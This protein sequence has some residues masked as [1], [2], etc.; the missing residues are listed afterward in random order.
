MTDKEKLNMLI[1]AIDY[2]F[3]N[4]TEKDYN[5]E[6]TYPVIDKVKFVKRMLQQEQPSEDLLDEADRTYF[7][8]A[9]LN[10]K[11][12]GYEIKKMT[13][14]EFRRVAHHFANWQKE[15]IMEDAV[16][17]TVDYPFIGHDFPNIYPNYRELKDYCDKNG[18]KDNA[19]VKLIMI[20]E[21]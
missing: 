17:A 20:K 21:D 15:K 4:P 8:L 2:S 11:Q 16:D 3:W 19:K 7:E 9:K 13:Q 1:E 6:L 14:G 18:I 5:R 12:D 10:N